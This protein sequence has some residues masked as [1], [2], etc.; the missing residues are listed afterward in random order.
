LGVTIRYAGSGYKA[1]VFSDLLLQG[2]I[3]SLLLSFILVAILL[4]LLFRS[5]LIGIAGTI[6]IA[7]TSVINF[8]VMGLTGIPLSSA[9]ALI[10]SIAIGIGVDY[11]IHLIEH[12]QTRRREGLDIMPSALATLAHTGRAI[13]YNTIAVMGGFAVL[14]ISV[15]PP[16]RQVGGLISLNMAASALGT[17]TVLMIVLTTLDRRGKLMKTKSNKEILV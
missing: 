11:A 13:I 17:L 14:L 7:I 3:I 1:L 6:P 9:T 5:V 4:A 2:Q 10:S 15:F 16:N 8:G 12:Y